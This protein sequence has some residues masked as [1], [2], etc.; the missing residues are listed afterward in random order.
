MNTLLLSTSTTN[1]TTKN[2]KII[3]AVICLTAVFVFTNRMVYA[4]NFSNTQGKKSTVDTKTATGNSSLDNYKGIENKDEAKK[5]WLQDNTKSIQQPP[6]TAKKSSTQVAETKNV[7]APVEVQKKAEPVKAEPAPVVNKVEYKGT[8]DGEIETTV[9]SIPLS[10]K[11]VSI[12]EA[13][14]K[15]AQAPAK[16]ETNQVQVTGSTSTVASRTNRASS[17][18]KFAEV[19]PYDKSTVVNDVNHTTVNYPAIPGFT[20]TGNPDADAKAFEEAKSKLYQSNPAE[21]NKYF[22]EK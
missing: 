13:Q 15:Q 12:K 3:A 7:P 9:V 19:K 5:A 20:P 14:A 4:Q 2:F 8:T 16:T 18:E 10:G 21:Y 17:V 22:S 1:C 11:I 6:R